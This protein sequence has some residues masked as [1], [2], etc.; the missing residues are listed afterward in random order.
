MFVG[1]FGYTC[2]SAQ[3]LY[4]SDWL[5]YSSAV[6]NGVGASL[7]WTG[8]GN[9][10]S[11]NTSPGRSARDSGI[12]WSLYQLSGVLGNIA[13]YFLFQGKVMPKHPNP[14][15]LFPTV[16][17]TIIEDDVRIKTA[18]TFTALCLLGQVITLMFRPTPWFQPSTHNLTNP[19]K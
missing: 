10:L 14:I 16:G 11:I 18:A 6:A 8:Q 15:I 13:V 9:F 5:L 1:G 4:L 7:L 17:V 3:M 19:L 12:F 2:Y